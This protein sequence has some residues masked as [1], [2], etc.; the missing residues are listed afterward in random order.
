MK[1]AL[2]PKPIAA[3][4]F[5]FALS[6]F[7]SAQSASS[8]SKQGYKLLEQ[9]KYA[10]AIDAYKKAVA[11]KP[12]AVDFFNIGV[13]YERLKQYEDALIYYNKAAQIKP[14][15]ADAWHRIGENHWKLKQYDQAIDAYRQVVKLKPKSSD[16]RELLSGAENQRQLL[17]NAEN[18]LTE[19]GANNQ[20]NDSI[21][22]AQPPSRVAQTA[23]YADAHILKALEML[24]KENLAEVEKSARRGIAANPKSGEAYALLAIALGNLGRE[25]EAE[26]ALKKALELLPKD[27]VWRKR[28]ED[29]MAGGEDEE[30]PQ[31]GNASQPKKAETVSREKSDGII[32]RRVNV[33]FYS[34]LNEATVLE[35]SGGKYKVRYEDKTAEDE[36]VEADRIIPFEFG[37]TAGGPPPGKY[38]CYMPMYENTYMGTF[39]VSASGNYQYQTGNKGSGKFKYNTETNAIEWTSGDLA[40]KGVTGEYFNLKENGPTIVLIFPKGKRAGDIQRCLKKD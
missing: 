30:T 6:W 2:F 27:S 16:A 7:A 34:I 9:E 10:E 20:S 14:K 8:F 1:N 31:N 37:D 32:G 25:A 5:I 12:D 19:S 33:K 38:V 18:Q 4:L 24:E 22:A 28:I 36:W 15:D 21:V 26:A 13:A 35:A 11:L 23:A 17:R 29:V 3:L 40:G 39:V